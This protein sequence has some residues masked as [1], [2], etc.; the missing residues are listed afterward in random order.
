MK[1]RS[2][3]LGARKIPDS[4]RVHG[5]RL[6]LDSQPFGSFNESESSDKNLPREISACQ[7]VPSDT[8]NEATVRSETG[9]GYLL[10]VQEVAD[11]LRVPVSWVYGRM[12]SRSRERLPGYRLGKYWRFQKEEVLTWVASHREDSHAA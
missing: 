9:T 5:L 4:P 10:T 7:P 2:T 3:Q 8:T 11:L 12:R 6:T 1:H